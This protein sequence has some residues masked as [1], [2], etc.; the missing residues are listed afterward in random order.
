M[1]RTYKRIT[2]I[3][4]WPESQLRDALAA[5]KDGMSVKKAAV[6]FNIPRTTLRRRI[7]TG[8]IEKGSLGRNPVFSNH[9][10]KE[11]ADHVVLLAKMF[12]GLTP[13]ELRRVAF[14]FAEKNNI[15]HNFNK[16][17]KEAGMDWYYGFL[18]RNPTVSLRSPEATSI[19][20][21]QAFNESEVKLFFDNLETLMEKYHFATNRIYNVDETGISTVQKPSKILGLKGQKQIGAATSWERGK[22]VTVTCA[23]NAAGGFIPPMFIFPRQRMN[24]LLKKDGPD[25]ALYEHSKNGWINEEIFLKWLVHFRDYC[26]PNSESPVLLILDNHSSHISLQIY[27]FCK[28]NN[29]ILLSIPPHTSHHLQPLDVVLYGPVKS[30]FNRE[31]GLFLKSCGHKKI[32]PYDLAALFNKAYSR[33]ASLDKGSKGFAVCGISPLD[34]SKFSSEDFAPAQ[35]QMPVIIQEDEQENGISSPSTR[36]ILTEQNIPRITEPSTT[37]VETVQ[38]DDVPST[39]SFVGIKEVAPIPKICH[40]ASIS[41]RKQ[42]SVILTATPLKEKL[43]E[44][45]KKKIAKLSKPNIK[46]QNIK[47]GKSLKGK[48]PK[49]K[50]LTKKTHKRKIT[51]SSSEEDEENESDIENLIDDE[52]LDDMNPEQ[53]ENQCMFC[54]EFGI[55]KELWFRCVGCG[56]WAH[57]LCSGQ[58]KPNNYI[59]DFCASK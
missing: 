16:N 50:K 13:I 28:E 8:K 42:H 53:E 18:R 34:P 5:V 29:I 24:P 44:K 37:L 6:V 12:F 22:T 55:D 39:S 58:D 4:S 21:I 48:G 11:I 36:N 33:V 15:S 45:E 57:A 23:F 43:E 27:N 35:H 19:N 41:N 2:N 25:G 30:A 54:S 31:C 49:T 59:C 1:P 32:T 52:E 20:R 46:K 17:A 9:Q 38:V 56:R 26:K 51:F 3:S 7:Q 40:G 10:E 14:E 47:K